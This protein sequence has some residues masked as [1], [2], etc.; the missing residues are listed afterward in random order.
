MS[1]Y[2][3]R[4]SVA[5][6]CTSFGV[7]VAVGQPVADD[8]DS[9][10]A[11]P[12][13][14]ETILV[15]GTRL[16][17]NSFQE[18]RTY[19]RERIDASGQTTVADFL[20]TVPEVSINSLEST[21]GATSV[22]LRGAR[23]GSTLILVNGR[24]TQASTGGAALIGF[25]DLNTLPLSMIER[26]DV[27]PTGSSAVYGGEALAG[28]VNI[29]LK[30]QFDG[31]EAG[32]AYKSASDTDEELVTAGAG[33]NWDSASLSIMGS[34]LERTALSGSEREITSSADYTRFGG[35][36][37]GSPFFGV[38]ATILSVSGNL[39][40]L[41]SNVAAV[42][43]GSTGVGLQ[44]ADFAGT[45]GQ[46]NLGTFNYYQDL[47]RPTTR[48]GLLVNANYRL[49]RGTELFAELLASEFKDD[50]LTTPPA[51]LQTTVP[52]TNAF[53]PFGTAVRA[54][55]VVRG[56]EPLATFT[57]RDELFRPLLG[58]R[59]QLGEWYWEATGLVSRDRGGQ[60]IYGQPN[61]A[62]MTAALASADPSAALNPFVDGPMAS[63]AMLSSIF[64]EQ[65]VTDWEGDATVLNGFARSSV[66]SLPAGTLGL[67]LGGEY[68]ESGLERGM[69]EDRSS[70]AAFMELR[71]PVLASRGA[72]REV[73]ALHAAARFDDYSDFGTEDTWQ[74]GIEYR[75]AEPLLLRAT[76]GTAFKPPTL[77]ALGA[78]VMSA[79]F[80]VIDP[81]R[82]RETAV[83]IA[84]QSGNPDL[85][86]TTGTSS[87]LGVVWSASKA[88]ELA[89][90]FTAWAL[91]IDRAITLPGT[92][93]IVDNE[94]LYPERIV[95]EPA[96]SGE[97]G[98]LVS[99]DGS[100][101]NFGS[102]E[103]EGID[104]SVSWTVRTAVGELRPSI[105]ATYMTKFVGASAPGGPDVDRLSRA[106]RDG[107]FA[108]RAKATASVRWNAGAAL[109]V[110]FAGRYVGRYYDYTP[111][112]TLGE[113]WYLDAAVDLAVGAMVDA[114]R[115]AVAGLGVSVSVANLTD[116]L[117]PYSAHF[118]GYDIYNYDLLGRTI[119]LRVRMDF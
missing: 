47:V 13:A 109:D 106:Q 119:L 27:Q 73:L 114:E 68:E 33:W 87:A 8:A 21:Y 78:P 95:R 107:I 24:R 12:Q 67:V 49:R 31:V 43:R 90:S 50:A 37:L 19:D 100:Y 1:A 84:S 92:Q 118:R 23:E 94:S 17:L 70:R 112:R 77:Y 39:P 117:P 41:G 65:I 48:T 115:R 4:S 56:T 105:A 11:N 53:N 86:P 10:A 5:A 44:P 6:L 64:S 60:V 80:P 28:V 18:V 40:G 81:Q 110:S 20:A 36:N 74:L 26:I 35:P 88:H 29:I 3:V 16:G 63:P 32:I 104:A 116:E 111:T 79:P 71:A 14:V 57:F 51:L 66:L 83:V 22:R 52:A 85:E 25:F 34:Y 96:A 2:P 59:G 113:H 89:V 82:N 72:P 93:Y 54:S 30:S 7:G 69:D 101:I 62:S 58:A 38:P 46:Q 97:V 98:R 75:P 42:P 15:T 102:M 99:V 91:E 61:P 108:P 45:A 76:H 9:R 103:E 55:G